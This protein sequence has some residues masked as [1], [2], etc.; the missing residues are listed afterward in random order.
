MAHFLKLLAENGIKQDVLTGSVLKA[1]Q[2]ISKD[3]N[4]THSALQK[5]SNKIADIIE[6]ETSQHSS[7]DQANLQA[8]FATE[9]SVLTDQPIVKGSITNK[10]IL[11]SFLNGARL[12]STIK[13]P[14]QPPNPFT[15]RALILSD[16][17]V[18]GREYEIAQLLANLDSRQNVHIHG[19]RRIG[20]SA[21]LLK[22]AA[23]LRMLRPDTSPAYLDMTNTSLHNLEGF[24]EVLAR[25]WSSKITLSHNIPYSESLRKLVESTAHPIM[26]LDGCDMFEHIDKF[27]PVAFLDVLRA[28]SSKRLCIVSAARSTLYKLSQSLG[29]LSPHS[30]TF[31]S[32]HLNGFDP[33]DSVAFLS[34]KTSGSSPFNKNESRVALDWG[35]DN[36]WRLQIVGYYIFEAKLNNKSLEWALEAAEEEWASYHSSSTSSN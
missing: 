7:S 10:T 33:K 9:L 29:T 6:A 11:E 3:G 35:G 8:K 27:F 32:F 36:P 17:A 19:E 21:V 18:F 12:D 22:L 16:Q 14:S 23:R 28:T 20:K 26:I 24:F 2:R 13:E 5:I 4:C 15:S 30:N 34:D 1:I 31:V 25:S